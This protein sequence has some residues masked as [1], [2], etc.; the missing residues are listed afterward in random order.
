MTRATE[1]TE[2]T[3]KKS[4]INSKPVLSKV[5]WIANNQS[6]GPPTEACPFNC[7]QGW[8]DKRLLIDVPR[9]E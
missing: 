1:S 7:V 8:L 4:I 3:E 5:E 9:F 6:H 2:D